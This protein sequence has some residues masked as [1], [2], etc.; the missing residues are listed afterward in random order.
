MPPRA[1]KRACLTLAMN[2]A[3]PSLLKPRRLTSA[4]ASG[5]R[6]MRGL[7]L[8]GCASGVT[9]PTSTKPKPIAPKASMQRPFLSSP[10]ARPM[11]LGKARPAIDTGSFTR[12]CSTRAISGVRWIAASAPRVR[13]CA[14]SGSSPNRKGR[15]SGKGMS[16]MTGA[17]SGIAGHTSR[18]DFRHGRSA[19]RERHVRRHRRRRRSPVGRADRAVAAPLRHLDREDAAASSSARSRGSSAAPPSSIATSARC[20]P[21]RP[22][23]SSPP[24][25]R[26]SPAGTTIS[27][28]SRSGR[29][30]RARRAT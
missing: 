8:P 27:S 4:P 7:G 10:A 16:A 26:S 15:A 21:R 20:R 23:R 13:S 14:C 2:A 3:R 25:T 11:R 5:M 24:P 18:Q 1:R 17:D 19:H 30:A 9:V 12:A 28:R 29:P 6:K 22:A